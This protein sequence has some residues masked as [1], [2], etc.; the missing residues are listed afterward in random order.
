LL[1]PWLCFRGGGFPNPGFWFSAWR[2]AGSYHPTVLNLLVDV[3]N[4]F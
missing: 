2:A 4:A 3:F 1:T